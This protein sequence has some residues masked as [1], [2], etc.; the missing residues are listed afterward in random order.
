[1]A[2]RAVGTLGAPAVG[3]VLCVGGQVDTQVEGGGGPVLGGACGGL[4]PTASTE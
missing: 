4:G 3:W 1:M 2:A